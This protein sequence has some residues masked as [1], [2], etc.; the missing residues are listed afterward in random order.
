MQI[1][2]PNRN[3][4]AIRTVSSSIRNP[5]EEMGSAESQS[6]EWLYWAALKTAFSRSFVKE[7][8]HIALE[9]SSTGLS[10]ED[11]LAASA[12]HGGDPKVTDHASDRSEITGGGSD[13]LLTRMAS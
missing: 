8:E 13:G 5:Q 4:T 2:N 6:P 1:L 12:P 9:L 7:A 3:A 11:C 10:Q